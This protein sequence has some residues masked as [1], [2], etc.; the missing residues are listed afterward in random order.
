[1]LLALNAERY[2]AEVNAGL[3][4]KGTQTAKKKTAAKKAAKKSPKP[5]PVKDSPQQS[6][7]L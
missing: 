1:L 2:Q 4:A 5:K 3:H 7:D 6:F